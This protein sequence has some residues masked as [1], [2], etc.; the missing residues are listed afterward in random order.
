MVDARLEMH[1]P[2]QIGD[3]A[4]DDIV[5]G[6]RHHP[7]LGMETVDVGQC[8]LFGN[9]VEHL[10]Q[11]SEAHIGLDRIVDDHEASSQG[12]IAG[13]GQD[14]CERGIGRAEHHDFLLAA[15]G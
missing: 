14:F 7:G 6:R 12:L 3:V 8:C 1:V 10:Q 2:R 4:D 11:Q 13:E 9:L 5:D 15:D